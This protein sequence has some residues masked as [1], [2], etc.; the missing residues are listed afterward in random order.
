MA[1]TAEK[2]TRTRRPTKA[3]Q[4][5]NTVREYFA[6]INRHDLD[7]MVGYYD[8]EVVLDLVPIG[9]KRGPGEYRAFFQ[10]LFGAVPDVEFTLARV[11]ANASIAA[12]EWRASGT[13]SGGPFQG[14]EA[15]GASVQI[16][17]CDCFEVKD[18]KIVANTAYYDG[19]E[20]ARSIGMMPALDS[21]GE[22]AMKQ[23]FNAVTK[24]R[25]MVQ[26]RRA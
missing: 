19:M 6:A 10:E 5:E 11:T 26:E 8:D 15:T 25:R 22:R 18:G 12:V 20:F 14:V 24:V 1:E 21:G 3:K 23:A 2:P 17:G 9:I 16:R 4:V 7:E 13:F